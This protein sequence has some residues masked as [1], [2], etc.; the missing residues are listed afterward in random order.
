MSVTKTHARHFEI[1][2]LNWSDRAALHRADTTGMYGI[3]DFR[4]GVD[5]LSAIDGEEIGD[6]SGLSI[7]HL[8]C[9]FGLDTLALARRGANVTGIDFSP[10]AIEEA[11]RLSEETGVAAEFIE[12]NVYD[13]PDRIGAPVDLV[14]VTW[15]TIC[16]LPDIVGWADVVARCLKPGGHLYFADC[17]PVAACFEEIDGI[18]RPTYAWRT[19]VDDPLSFEEDTSYAGTGTLTHKRSVEWIHPLSDLVNALMRAG[20]SL[21]MLRE[22]DYLPWPLFACMERAPGRLFRLPD[23]VPPFPLS[24]SLKAAKPA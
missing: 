3:D 17:H 20:L 7:L 12:A 22:H 15:G 8:Q 11:R 5:V 19:P 4:N 14:Y 24:V 2:R 16:W 18:I 1:N 13:A 23:T 6:V 10:V 9:H 21:T